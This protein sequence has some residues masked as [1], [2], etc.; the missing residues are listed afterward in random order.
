MSIIEINKVRTSQPPFF[1]NVVSTSTKVQKFLIVYIYFFYFFLHILYKNFVLI[2]L[3]LIKKYDFL[4]KNGQK[5][6]ILS[7]FCHFFHFP[8][9]TKFYFC[10]DFVLIFVLVLRNFVLILGYFYHFQEKRQKLVF[11]NF[12]QNLQKSVIFAILYLY[13]YLYLYL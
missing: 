7:Y 8:T 12:Y 13:L 2:V 1:R 4:A 9:S 11:K 5:S 3:V 6:P 10:L